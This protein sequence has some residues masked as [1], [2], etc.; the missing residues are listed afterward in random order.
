[1]PVEFEMTGGNG[2]P[3]GDIVPGALLQSFYAGDRIVCPLGCG[4]HV[5]AVRVGT[6][7]DGGGDLWFECGC[8]AQRNR[9]L[10]P[11]ATDA[12]RSALDVEFPPGVAPVCPRHAV[13]VALRQHGRQLICPECGV[14]FRE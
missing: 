6:L 14:R 10:V 9:V 13:R 1:M 4:G 7:D 5:H 8:C 12:E 3:S 11:R 2:L